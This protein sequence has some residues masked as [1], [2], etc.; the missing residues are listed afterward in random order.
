MGKPRLRL[1]VVLRMNGPYYQSEYGWL[2]DIH[3]TTLSPRTEYK[4]YRANGKEL[5]PKFMKGRS[6]FLKDGTIQYIIGIWASDG[7][8]YYRMSPRRDAYG[9]D[10]YTESEICAHYCRK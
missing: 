3:G 8:I 2:A 1:P 9:H 4:V 7:T 6:V 10:D 5:Y